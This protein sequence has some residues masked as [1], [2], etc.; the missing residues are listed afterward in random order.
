MK[1]GLAIS[2]LMILIFSVPFSAVT[3]GAENTAA[4]D[5]NHIIDLKEKGLIMEVTGYAGELSGIP[6]LGEDYTDT[7][8]HVLTS[9]EV[10]GFPEFGLPIYK[11]P[12]SD[13][14]IEYSW[15]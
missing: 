7:P 1:I 8:I 13:N 5:G 3:Y 15:L 2:F 11:I 10:K 6:E 9:D 4:S 14:Y 12:F